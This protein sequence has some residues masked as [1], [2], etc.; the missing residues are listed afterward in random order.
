LN[1]IFKEINKVWSFF[2]D[3]LFFCILSHLLNQIL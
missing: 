2:W 3:L 1:E